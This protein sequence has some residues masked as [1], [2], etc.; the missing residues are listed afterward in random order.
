MANMKYRHFALFNIIGGVSWIFSMTM[1]GYLLVTMFPA[2][3]QHI[4]KVIIVV[5][6]ISFIPAIVEYM[7]H[8]RRPPSS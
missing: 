3:E 1:I 7:R 2:T 4:E 8:R 6:F 5:L